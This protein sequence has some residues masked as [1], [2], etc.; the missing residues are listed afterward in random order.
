MASIVLF[1]N[2]KNIFSKIIELFQDSPIS[3]CGIGLTIN[4]LPYVLHAAFLGVAFAPRDHLLQTHTIVAE[5]AIVPNVDAELMQA[6]EKY[7]GDSY[8]TFGLI[9]F[10]FV[11]LGRKIKRTIKNPFASKNALV[12]SELIVDADIDHLIPE[13]TGLVPEDTMPI[14]IYNICSNG[15]SFIRLT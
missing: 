10:L 6:A 5:F 1:H 13:F 3:H 11:L 12:C 2:Q 7:I 8:D 15:K 4:G 9:G 14:D